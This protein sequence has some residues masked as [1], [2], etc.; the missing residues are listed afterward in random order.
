MKVDAVIDLPEY[1]EQF[2]FVTL[3]GQRVNVSS[4]WVVEDNADKGTGPF[5]GY[6]LTERIDGEDHVWVWDAA[7]GKESLHGVMHPDEGHMRGETDE[8]GTVTYTRDRLERGRLIVYRSDAFDL[9][10]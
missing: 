9:R 7:G 1:G 8:E 6:L 5:W 10:T 4:G 3:P 2:E